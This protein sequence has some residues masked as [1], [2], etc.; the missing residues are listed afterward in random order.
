MRDV[1]QIN[2]SLALRA[3]IAQLR[4]DGYFVLAEHHATGA[5]LQHAGHRDLDLFADMWATVFDHNH[6]AVVQVTNALLDSIK[7][8]RL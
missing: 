2:H 8:D 5:C 1:A 6:C 4:L 3:C 7:S